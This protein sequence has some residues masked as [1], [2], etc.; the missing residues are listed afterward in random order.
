MCL[1]VI[2]RCQPLSP[3]ALPPDSETFGGVGRVLG[4]TAHLGLQTAARS[5]RL[6][7]QGTWVDAHIAIELYEPRTITTCQW[8]Q[9]RPT[10]LSWVTATLP[11]SASAAVARVRVTGSYAIWCLDQGFTLEADVILT[12]DLIEAW[13]TSGTVTAR[14][15]GTYRSHLRTVAKANARKAIWTPTPEPMRRSSLR[16][17]Y[18]DEE[19]AHY[20]ALI[21]V[22]PTARRSQLLD[23]ILHIGL[24]LG[25]TPSEMHGLRVCDFHRDEDLVLV[26]VGDRTVPAR[27]EFALDIIRLLETTEGEHLFGDHLGEH[28]RFE[29]LINQ[30]EIPAYLPALRARR[31]R[32]TWLVAVLGEANLTLPE[33]QRVSGLRSGRVLDDLVPFLPVDEDTYLRRA[34]GR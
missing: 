2:P 4:L 22:Q 6:W 10:I 29:R 28:R 21:D 20:R 18:S 1:S 30:V 14:S 13:F 19:I 16:D 32:T 34:A 9:I 23:L 15:T 33:F 31:L 24:G 27:R 7:R 11:C 5:G 17:P 12:E 8:A 3:A 26:V 25:L